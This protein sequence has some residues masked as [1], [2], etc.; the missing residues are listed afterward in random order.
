VLPPLQAGAP[1]C[2]VV[3][4]NVYE[5]T[6]WPW[7]LTLH[8]PPVRHGGS[9]VQ[10]TGVKWQEPDPSQVPGLQAFWEQSTPAAWLPSTQ[11]PVA[12]L[13]EDVLHT[14]CVEHE[15]T[16]G[17]HWPAWHL[18]SHGCSPHGWPSLMLVYTQRPCALQEPLERHSVSGHS[19]GVETH[20]DVAPFAW[21]WSLIVQGFKSSQAVLS[22]TGTQTHCWFS[23]AYCMH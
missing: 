13:Q 12:V 5:Q 10:V 15:V 9:L 4:A 7:L 1:H 21:Q 14:C 18:V 17:A 23:M 2:V 3:S 16:P 19:L 8:W 6:A 22:G 11:W 20:V